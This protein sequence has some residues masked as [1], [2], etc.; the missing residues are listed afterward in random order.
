MD[1]E[2]ERINK[3]DKEA[4]LEWR[5]FKDKFEEIDSIMGFKTEIFL[6]MWQEI[7]EKIMKVLIKGC[8]F[9]DKVNAIIKEADKK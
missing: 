4:I 7:S 1:E 8:T 5:K 2:L 6:P 3:L 9:A